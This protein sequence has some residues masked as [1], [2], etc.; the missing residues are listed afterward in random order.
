MAAIKTL[1]GLVSWIAANMGAVNEATSTVA[2]APLPAKKEV[3]SRIRFALTPSLFGSN[4]PEN[5]NGQQFAITDDGS[6]VA[7]AI[8]ESLEQQGAIVNIISDN[9]SLEGYNGLIILDILSTP[10]RKDILSAFDTIK[11]LHPE[12][13]KWVYAISDIDTARLRN[14]QGYPGFLKS[15]DKEWDHTK[16]RSIS[17][18]GSLSPEEIAAITLQEVLHPDEP[19]EII[20]QDGV[21]HTFQLI[22][23]QVPTG[24]IPNIKLDRESVILVL[25]GAQGITAELMVRFSKDYPCNY[26]L[27]GR[28][29]DPRKDGHNKYAAFKNKED[30]KKQ[31]IAEGQYSKP[32]EIEKRASDIHKYNQILSTITSLEGNGATVTYHTLDLRNEQELSNLISSV[33]KDHGRIDGVIHGAGL[34]EDKLFQQKTS[35][36]F[37]RVFSTKVTPL[38]IL[39]EQLRPDVQFVILFSSVASVY[40]NRG[41]TD[42]AAA[43]SVMDRYAWELNKTLKGKVVAINWG[44]WKGT[45]MVSPTLEKEY[46]RRGIPLIPLKDGMEVFVNELKY[47]NESQVLIMAE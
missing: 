43:N 36:S 20:Y 1:N 30:I 19:A 13:V 35:D 37:E 44:P 21:R 18:T 11:K 9:D 34:L 46:E 26:I 2:E 22:P 5:L 8:R 33:Y 7:V 3:L 14:F 32:A 40:G 25:G 15:L 31:L 29:A 23:S 6:K 41:Q 24:D 16:C 28:S 47:G 12:K 39:A 10:N 38:R 42:Y 45:G 4:I 17:L 27:V